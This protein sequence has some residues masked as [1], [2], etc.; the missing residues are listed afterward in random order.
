MKTDVM[1][2][3]IVYVYNHDPHTLVGHLVNYMVILLVGK[4]R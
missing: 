2:G 1:Q 4:Y 3:L